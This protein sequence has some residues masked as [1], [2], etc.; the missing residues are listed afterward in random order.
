MKRIGIIV[1]IMFSLNSHASELYTCE[2]SMPNKS[3]C[4]ATCP[5]GMKV[6]GG[7]CSF[8]AD[9]QASW[10]EESRVL[11]N[12]AYPTSF[13]PVQRNGKEGYFCEAVSAFRGADNYSAK[14]TVTATA[15]CQ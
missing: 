4:T 12:K 6:L 1:C 15:I 5:T 8:T 2:A 13:G 11:T 3:K 9:D 7:G 10:N 14:I